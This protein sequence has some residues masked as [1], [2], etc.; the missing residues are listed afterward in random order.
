MQKLEGNIYHSN[1]SQ[2][3]SGKPTIPLMGRNLHIER[4]STDPSSSPKAERYPIPTYK[5]YR[6]KRGGLDPQ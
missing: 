2:L 1:S 6:I 4:K 3:I 5:D